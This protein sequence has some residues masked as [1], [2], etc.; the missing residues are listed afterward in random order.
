[1]KAF[2]PE[3]RT[4][5]TAP[6]PPGVAGDTIVAP[7]REPGSF[8]LV[9]SLTQSHFET[10]PIHP[11][12]IT[13]RPDLSEKLLAKVWAACLSARPLPQGTPYV[14]PRSQAG[15]SKG[16]AGAVRARTANKTALKGKPPC[17]VRCI[18]SGSQGG[19]QAY[20]RFGQ[21]KTAC[22]SARKK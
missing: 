5:D 9:K 14:S 13:L 16:S 20:E 3:S 11:K 12:S 4:I 7:S 15:G 1:M 6:S 19:T 2:G 22:E 8:S 18:A 17:D 21:K 10:A